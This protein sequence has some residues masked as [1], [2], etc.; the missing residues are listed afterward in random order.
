[1]II[2]PKNSHTTINSG[3]CRSEQKE[4]SCDEK[5]RTGNEIPGSNTLPS[6]QVVRHET[7]EK[8]PMRE[9]G[10][11]VDASNDNRSTFLK[12][13]SGQLWSMALELLYKDCYLSPSQL[14]V[15]EKQIMKF[16]EP[17]STQSLGKVHQQYVSRIKMAGEY[18]AKD[19]EKRYVQLPD[20]YFST[21]NP[22]GF[23]GT[24]AW[25]DKKKKRKA[26]IEAKSILHK[27][28]TRILKAKKKEKNRE[29]LNLKLFRECEAQIAKLKDS[30]SI[31]RPKT[32]YGVRACC[33]LNSH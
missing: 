25:Y 30:R 28:L 10:G 23:R 13:L 1:M 21:H 20:R 19:P 12:L 29:S 17:V 5:I 9:A 8:V 22:F 16:Y 14:E 26:Q 27:Q 24:K 7:R 4:K 11:A 32:K 6:N 18:I 33:F 15:G 31:H 3:Q 2:P